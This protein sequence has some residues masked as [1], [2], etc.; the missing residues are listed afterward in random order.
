MSTYAFRLTE[1]T[2]A[3]VW[4][5]LT[6]A[7][8]AA[9][10]KLNVGA[11]LIVANDEAASG[12]ATSALKEAGLAYSE[13]TLSRRSLSIPEMDC[14]IEERDIQKV[15][16]ERKIADVELNVMTRTA[17][18]SGDERFVETV[19]DAV[20]AAGYEAKR[21]DTSAVTR[22]TLAIP[23]MDCPVEEQDIRKELDRHGID[24]VE[25]NVMSR[26]AVF[27]GNEEKR[28]A[29]IAAVV[30]AGYQARII[31]HRTQAV[32]DV[33]IPYLR[34]GVALLIAFLSEGLDIIEEYQV[35]VLP[36]SGETIAI[37]SLVLAVVA[38]LMAGLGTLKEGIKCL[39]RWEFNMMT[40]MAVAVIGA[41]LIGAWP[42]A[43]MVMVLFEISETIEDLCMTKARRSI[44]DLMAFTPS[45]A[46]LVTLAGTETVP[47]SEI[48]PGAVIRVSPGDRFPLDGKI[49]VGSTTT[50]QANVTGE[51]LPVDKG[52]GDNVWSGTVNLTSTVDVTVTAA[53]ADSLTARIIEAVENAQAA[54]S[55]VQR[56]VDK[57]AAIYT[58][59]VFVV[60]IAAAIIPPFIWGDWMGWLYKAFCLLVIACPCA[61]VISTPV[62]FASAL[63]TATRCGLLIK[64]G[65]YLEQARQL[66]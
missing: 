55:P 10:I 35:D 64:G 62:T 42:E 50:D 38:I 63:G 54:K 1:P 14:P 12:K 45:S 28:D 9:G 49:L 56:F 59:I 22:H 36:L 19:I 15:L 16:D 47:V 60:A 37:L 8:S 39:F 46:Q 53:E 26:T 4:T 18:F 13:V 17:N 61:L 23:E 5:K 66:K 33:K 29:V 20:K 57:F 30:A 41:V 21:P 44:R 6:E 40:L 2:S 32:E 3:E 24:G 31:A 7:L 11:E 52:P 43:A 65:L 25:L 51:S 48:A 34:F 58:P 27:Q